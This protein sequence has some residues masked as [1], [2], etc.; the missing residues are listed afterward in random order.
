M[1]RVRARAATVLFALLLLPLAWMDPAAGVHEPAC[2]DFPATAPPAS[3]LVFSESTS[4]L[5]CTGNDTSGANT[6]YNFS[7]GEPCEEGIDPTIYCDL[8]LLQVDLDDPSFWDTRGGGVR[9]RLH[10]FEVPS[11]DYDLQ[12]WASDAAGNKGS[13]LVGSSGNPPGSEEETTISQPDGYYLIQVVYFAVVDSHYHMT[14]EFSTR[15]QVPPDV[16]VPPGLQEVLVSQ[17][18]YKSYSE[19]HIAQNPRNPKILIAGSK[20]YNKDPHSLQEYEFKVG[21]FVS[22]DGGKTW[23]D[24]GPIKTCP[25]DQAPPGT[26]PFNTCYPADDPDRGGTGAEDDGDRGND[27]FGEEY[28][29]SDPWVHFD[30]EGNA[31]FMVLDAPPFESGARWGMTMHRWNSVSKSDLEPGGNTWSN[32]KPINL[33]DMDLPQDFLGFLDD[34]NTFAVQN[35]GPDSDGTTGPLVACWGQ[36]VSAAVKQQVACRRSTD[37]GDTWEPADVLSGVHQLVIGVHVIADP[38]DPNVFYATWLQYETEIATGLGTLD[39]NVSVDGGQ[40]W[41]PTPISITDV[42]TIPRQFPGQSFRNLSIPIMAAGPDGELYIAIAE[43]LEAPDP[44]TDEDDLQADIILYKSTNGGVAWDE[45]T[46][47]TEGLEPNVNADQFQPVVDVVQEGN[48]KGQVNIGYFDRRL[49]QHEGFGPDDHPG[50]YFTDVF[51]S[52]SNDGGGTF[53]HHRLTHDATDPEYNAPVSGSGLFF[54]DYQ[55]LVVDDCR[56]VAFFNDTH[57]ANDAFIDPAPGQRDPDFD[58]GLPA[59]EFQQAASWRIPNT[60]QYGGTRNQACS[61]SQEGGGGGGG[62]NGGG[63]GGSEPKPAEPVEAQPTFTG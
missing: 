40:T 52:R 6:E 42:Q 63:G 14:L 5:T 12:I 51:L 35:A 3:T 62:G 38:T 56:A 39:F 54:G 1:T 4:P 45:G 7:S 43:Y 18:G 46:N 53:S 24:L 23:T 57:L 31:Y 37:R 27:D 15:D 22:F 11:S 10:D 9:I 26:W 2:S 36:N 49:D 55:G 30:D 58:D 28:I 32:R 34:K 29:T 8:T 47:V 25:Q 48:G 20:F 44:D 33:Y 59:R 61:A 17:S 21:T 41:L 16:D 50:N 13:E 19:L 60:T